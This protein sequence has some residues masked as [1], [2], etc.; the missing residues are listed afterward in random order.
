[1]DVQALARRVE[2]DLAAAQEQLRAAEDKVAEAQQQVDELRALR[3]SFALAVERYGRTASP[4]DA[5]VS[6]GAKLGRSQR[7]PRGKRKSAT[8]TRR[9]TAGANAEPASVP[10]ADG[11]PTLANACLAALVSF[12][13]A[14]TTNEIRDKL[15]ESGRPVPAE[16]IRSSLGYLERR[17]QKIKRVGRALW[18]P[19][20]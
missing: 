17:A 8:R 16:R 10:G 11:E 14:A 12:G 3:D 7:A 9:S 15:A 4:A 1:M 6:G 2:D 20:G 13:R 5:A 18:E 19:Q